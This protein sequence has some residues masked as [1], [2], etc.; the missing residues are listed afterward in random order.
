MKR[1]EM[2]DLGFS[3][4]KHK[5]GEVIISRLGRKVTTL[6]GSVAEDFLQQAEGADAASLQQLLARITGN[7]KRGN[8]RNARNHPRNRQ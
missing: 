3:F 2:G 4:E 8:E 5:N 1:A 6:R 7:Y